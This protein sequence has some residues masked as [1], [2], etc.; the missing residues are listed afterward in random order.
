MSA[1]LPRGEGRIVPRPI[2]QDLLVVVEVSLEAARQVVKE[3]GGG[4][5]GGVDGRRCLLLR[6]GGPVSACQHM[7]MSACFWSM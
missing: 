4:A 2:G 3:G 5:G 6:G 7:L 1:A